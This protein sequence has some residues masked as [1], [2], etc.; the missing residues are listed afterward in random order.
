MATLEKIRQ[1]AVLVSIVVA[2]ALF[3]FI[4]ESGLSSGKS[5]FAD[6][7]QVVL[8]I[9]DENI[10]YSEYSVKLKA[11]EDNM[12]QNGHSVTDEQQMMVNNQL[13]QSY[14]ASYATNK[15][16]NSLGLVVSDT[17]LSSLIYGSNMEMS[18]EVKQFFSSLGIDPSNKDQIT[19]FLKRISSDTNPQLEPIRLQW[20][21]IRDAIKEARLNTK[22]GTLLTR[23]FKLN[24]VDDELSSFDKS[25]VVKYVSLQPSTA[26]TTVVVSD[27]DMKKYYDEHKELYASRYPITKINTIY[28]NIVPSNSDYEKAKKTM[29][30]AVQLLDSTKS[31]EALQSLLRG[32]TTKFNTPTYMT[33]SEI[34][35]LGL[36][37]NDMDFIRTANV[38]AVNNPLVVND[39]YTIVK[40]TAKDKAPAS[41]SLNIIVL[42]SIYSTKTDSLLVVLNEKKESFSDMA[43]SISKDPHSSADGGRVS[44]PGQYGQTL[45]TFSEAQ[46]AQLGIKDAYKNGFGKPFVQDL[47]DFKSIVMLTDPKEV[48]DRYMFAL[49]NIPVTFSEETYNNK[50]SVIN[51]IL[52]SNKSFD[53]MAT[54]AEKEGLLVSRNTAVSAQQPTILNIPSS[55]QVIRWALNAKKGEVSPNLY[56]CGTDHLV[57]A[58]VADHVDAG[59]LPFDMVKDQIRGQLL[60]DKR[61]E[62]L[63]SQ[64]NNNKKSTLEDYASSYN[65]QIDSVV[66]VTY[67]V[68]QSGPEFSAISMNTPLEQLSNP[69][70]SD[71]Q[72]YIVKPESQ[73]E[74]NIKVFESQTKQRELEL[75]R[76]I[77]YRVFS[78]M[79]EDIKVVDN[80]GNF[81]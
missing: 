33:G 44:I 27:A 17:E 31:Q 64:V 38:G 80:R 71:G 69:F 59:Y 52:N 25:R 65:T 43:K 53:E 75:A 47:G 57:I 34:E 24:K 37:S 81:Y 30:E 3:I 74:S 78:Q 14:I 35:N 13:A 68:K 29:T 20:N 49:V 50:Y 16:S 39:N 46:M 77:G 18:P 42:D 19:D 32:Y 8:S 12:R 70:V 26:D 58:Q 60:R 72:V 7:K 2:V 6:S 1:R 10:K 63:L 40:L 28:T 76:Q 55:R 15:I 41:A 66:G 62:K 22:I 51:N 23:S 79:V 11:M 54:M 21:N 73:E 4:I 67:L 5:F 48:V 9:D 56:A 36:N 45:N 61:A